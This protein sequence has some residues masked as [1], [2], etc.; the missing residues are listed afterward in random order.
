MEPS[1]DFSIFAG[2]S[3]LDS[4]Y[5]WVLQ[6]GMDTLD[7]AGIFYRDDA[8]DL[9][10]RDAAEVTVSTLDDVK[11]SVDSLN[12][13]LGCF[14]LLFVVLLGALIGWLAGRDVLSIW[15]S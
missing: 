11:A 12:Y 15:I 2:D 7:D 6:D 10:D 14:A 4:S 9:R 8:G 3:E 13:N 5:D 1:S